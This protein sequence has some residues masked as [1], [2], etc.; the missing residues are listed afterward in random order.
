[1]EK[2]IGPNFDDYDCQNDPNDINYDFP[3]P[4][5]KRIKELEE[6]FEELNDFVERFEA[7]CNKNNKSKKHYSCCEDCG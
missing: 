1:L 5:H 2:Y 7:F 4:I 3:N 6:K